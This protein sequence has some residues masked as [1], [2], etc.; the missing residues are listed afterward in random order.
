MIIST[1][2]W[3]SAGLPSQE[4]CLRMEVVWGL[5]KCPKGPCSF[6]SPWRCVWVMSIRGENNIHSDNKFMVSYIHNSLL[7]RISIRRYGKQFVSLRCKEA[8]SFIP[9]NRFNILKWIILKCVRW[10]CM[11]ELILKFQRSGAVGILCV[12]GRFLRGCSSFS[13]NAIDL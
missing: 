5:H 9:G 11:G 8:I 2:V 4:N 1:Y 3:I 13:Q 7:S 10:L 6:Q 12:R